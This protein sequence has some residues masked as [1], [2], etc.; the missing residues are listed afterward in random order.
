MKMLKAPQPRWRKSSHSSAEGSDCVEVSVIQH[1]LHLARDSK[2]PNGPVLTMP[3]A[4]WATLIT[5]IKHG[6]YDL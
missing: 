5:N 4:T 2:N 1:H 3:S 6:V